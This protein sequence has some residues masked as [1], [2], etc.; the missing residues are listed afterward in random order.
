MQ[1][2]VSA[3]SAR[4][5]LAAAIADV[6]QFENTKRELEQQRQRLEASVYQAV[7]DVDAARQALGE[8]ERALSAYYLAEAQGTA[9]G[10]PPSRRQLEDAV[11]EAELRL[12]ARRDAQAA[13]ASAI[14][15]RPWQDH[16][17]RQKLDAAIAAVL[18]ADGR[19]AAQAVSQHVA[20]L[21]REL[22][23]WGAA[24]LFLQEM[25]AYEKDPEPG[26]S[27]GQPIDNE[28]RR[29]AKR[30]LAAPVD[31]G[32]EAVSEDR[33]SWKAQAL[34]ASK[35]WRQAVA[36]LATDPNVPLPDGPARTVALVGKSPRLVG[37]AA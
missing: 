28:V 33:D 30:L 11:E 16:L 31:W 37:S 7:E 34:D 12:Q 8:F 29:A 26:G 22:A 10:K 13:C 23:S 14:R 9:T 27:H 19:D 36:A 4:Q 6:Q 35:P 5:A 1:K 21:Q 2:L 18:A 3:S 20:G 17:V 32:S 24:L 15:D 25:G